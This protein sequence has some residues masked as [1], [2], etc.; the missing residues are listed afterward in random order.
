MPLPAVEQGRRRSGRSEEETGDGGS[1]LPPPIYSQGEANH[2]PP[3]SKV[4]MTFFFMQQGLVKLGSSR[5]SVGKRRQPTIR[6]LPRVNQGRRMLGPAALRTCPLALPQ[7]QARARLGLGGYCRRSGNEG[8]QTCLPAA[9]GVAVLA[10]LYGPSSS[11]RQSRP[12]RGAKPRE[13]DGARPPQER[14]P[15]AASRG[16]EISK[17]GKPREALVT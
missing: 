9:H 5:G 13:G 11:T 17:Q 1:T 14:P 15:Q 2:R 7:S 10:G 12:S 6:Q 16:A 4:I 3:Q 8:P